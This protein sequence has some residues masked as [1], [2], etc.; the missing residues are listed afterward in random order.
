MIGLSLTMVI[1]KNRC[2]NTLGINLIN[3]AIVT[4][5]TILQFYRSPNYTHRKERL[6]QCD[7]CQKISQ[8]SHFKRHLRMHIG[9][10]HY[11]FSVC[12]KAVSNNT[13]INVH[14]SVNTGER[15]YQCK[16]FENPFSKKMIL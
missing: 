11:Q 4:Q 7:Q 1:F 5:H 8:N 9:E 2:R 16:K 14:L 6:Y 15:S 10:R 3:V 13:V 12:D